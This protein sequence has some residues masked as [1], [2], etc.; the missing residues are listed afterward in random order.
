MDWKERIAHQVGWRKSLRALIPGGSIK[1]KRIK[2]EC[3]P[4]PS[5]IRSLVG[6]VVA[7][8]ISGVEAGS[9]L[10]QGVTIDMGIATAVFAYRPTPFNPPGLVDAEGYPAYPAM[11]VE[12]L[13]TGRPPSSGRGSPAP[14][15]GRRPASP[16]GR[17]SGP[18][19]S[20]S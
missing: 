13:F 7:D 8:E 14:A 17:T 12:P 19:P 16:A 2:I 10:L 3:V 15:P 18:S 1:E 4:D 5:V 9:L 6:C 11:S 20:G